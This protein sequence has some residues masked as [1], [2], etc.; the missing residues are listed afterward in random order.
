MDRVKCKNG[1]PVGI[2]LKHKVTLI[3]MSLRAKMFQVHVPIFL[4]IC[5]GRFQM[6]ALMDHIDYP[7]VLG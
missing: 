5:S 7:L 4:N 6:V 2:V 1:D 3:E